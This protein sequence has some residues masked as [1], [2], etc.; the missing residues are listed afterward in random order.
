MTQAAGTWFCARANMWGRRLWLQTEHAAPS[1][2][3]R[4]WRLSGAAEHRGEYQ[5]MLREGR[6]ETK[7]GSVADSASKPRRPCHSWYPHVCLNSRRRKQ[8][9]RRNCIALNIRR[10]RH[11]MRRSLES[12]QR[13]SHLGVCPA[14]RA[15]SPHQPNCP[16]E[17]SARGAERKWLREDGVWS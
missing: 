3:E 6:A 9:T 15:S 5:D 12:G 14:P 2:R 16:R 11:G 7:A 13:R 8:R 4:S 1:T 10:R 17:W